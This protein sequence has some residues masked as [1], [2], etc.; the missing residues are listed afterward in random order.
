MN[1]GGDLRYVTEEDYTSFGGRQKRKEAWDVHSG[2]L[3]KFV[4]N[5]FNITHVHHGHTVFSHADMH[6]EWAQIGVDDM[7]FMATQAILNGEYRAP[8]FTTKG[9]HHIMCHPRGKKI[10]AE[11][12]FL[13]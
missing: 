7:N 4:L 10:N 9:N 3:G 1:I 12:A 11:R 6:P 5:N 8:I 2:W 13:L